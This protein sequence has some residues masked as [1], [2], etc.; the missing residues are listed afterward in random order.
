MSFN[1]VSVLEMIG[2][3]LSTQTY[4]KFHVIVAILKLEYAT[5]TLYYIVEK[6][7]K[8]NLTI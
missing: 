8:K 4:R 1:G 2:F 3:L 5:Q 7:I 6:N